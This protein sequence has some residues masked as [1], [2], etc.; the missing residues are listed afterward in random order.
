V[1][2][3]L[4]QILA[5]RWIVGNAVG[6][7]PADESDADAIARVLRLGF[8]D[9]NLEAVRVD[10]PRLPDDA[11]QFAR[12]LPAQPVKPWP[13]RVRRDAVVGDPWRDVVVT[14]MGPGGATVEVD[15]AAIVI[16]QCAD[17]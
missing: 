8:A 12:E 9:D 17:A 4:L 1:T 11:R 16:Y 3:D 2:A 5:R 14:G 13:W 7:K 6:S 15:G 10:D